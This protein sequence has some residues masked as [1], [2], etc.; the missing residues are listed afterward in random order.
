[1]TI[2]ERGDMISIHTIN[3]TNVCIRSTDVSA[4]T[5]NLIEYDTPNLFLDGYLFK[6]YLL[7]L[8]FPN[9]NL[10]P[11]HDK[12]AFMIPLDSSNI[13]ERRNFDDDESLGVGTIQAHIVSTANSYITT[14]NNTFV[15]PCL[16]LN[17]ESVNHFY[18]SG[19]TLQ[20][21]SLGDYIHYVLNGNSNTNYDTYMS[22][23]I[24]SISSNDVDL[25]FS[26]E[27]SATTLEIDKFS[28]RHAYIDT[29]IGHVQSSIKYKS[30]SA[31]CINTHGFP[32]L[33]NGVIPVDIMFKSFLD[34]NDLFD[35]KLNAQTSNN[36]IMYS[37]TNFTNS[38]YDGIYYYNLTFSLYDS[39]QDDELYLA[40]NSHLLNTNTYSSNDTY[41]F[42]E[43]QSQ[44][45]YSIKLSIFNTHTYT[46]VDYGTCSSNIIL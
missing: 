32:Q 35:V 24:F 1:M 6:D 44:S 22:S 38:R 28:T 3:A 15:E 17:F 36:S 10:P 4:E 27:I 42:N 8:V 13:V 41:Y 25:T 20:G 7:N 39:T 29:D 34:E 11:I 5:D 33:Y 46:T 14:S 2:E 19:H 16:N 43:L 23:N 37:I 21:E 45:N 26:G 31:V 30:N 12:S 18:T 9:C 40:N